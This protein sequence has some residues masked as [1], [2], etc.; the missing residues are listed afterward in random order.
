MDLAPVLQEIVNRSG[1]ASGNA[2][3]LIVTGSGRRVAVSYEGS[4]AGAPLLH[5]EYTTGPPANQAPTVD[6][7]Q[8]QTVYVTSEALLDGAVTDDGLPAP[9]GAVTTAWDQ[10]SGPGTATLTDNTAVDTA[11]SF[12]GPG[13]YVLRLSAD[14]GELTASDEV[15]ISAIAP[16][17]NQPPAVDAG[18]DRTITLPAPA[19]LAGAVSDDGLPDPPG[20]VTL[21]WS[22][23][24]GPGT[25]TFAD[26]GAPDTTAAFA[27]D[28]VY[29]LRLSAIDGELDASDEMTVTVQAAVPTLA[30]TWRRWETTL[31]SDKDYA[32]PYTDASVAVTY[33]GPS[34]QVLSSLGFW[35]GEDRFKIR[36]M[37]PAAGT[38]TWVTTS[39]DSSNEGLHLQGGS[40]TVEPYTGPNRLYQGGYLQAQ[41]DSRHLTDASGAPFLWIGDTAW[42][43]PLN[44]ALADWQLY[45]DD[46]REKQ[47]TVLHL[48]TCGQWGAR[49]DPDTGQTIWADMEGNEPFLGADLG[50]LNPAFWQGYEQ[51]VQYANDRGLVVL[52]VGVMNPITRG[53]TTDDEAGVLRFAQSFAARMRGNFVLFSPGFDDEELGTELADKVAAEIER[54]SDVHLITVH[55]DPDSLEYVMQYY[56]KPYLDFVSL[57]TGRGAEGGT[58]SA[59]LASQRAIQR[60]L[61]LYGE[62]LVRPLINLEAR[63]DGSFTQEQMPRLP[64]SLGYLSMLSGAKG[65]SY[66][67][68]GLWNWKPVGYDTF[69]LS[70]DTERW[71]W[72]EA[73]QRASSTDMRHKSAF[74]AGIEWWRLEPRHDLIQNQALDDAWEHKMAF[75]L[76]P[77]GDLGVAYLP[78]NARIDLDMSAFSTLVLA[79]WYDPSAGVYAAIGGK[80]NNSGVRSLETP[81]EGDWLLVLTPTA[82]DPPLVDAGP[83]KEIALGEEDLLD[84]T[85]TDDGLPH[86]PG[87]TAVMWSQV[88]GPGTVTLG[89]ASA[90]DTTAYF[91][92]VGEYVLRL[93]ADDGALTASD[94][95]TITVIE[96]P[97]NQAPMVDAGPDQDV[98]IG[99]G[100]ALEGTVSDDGWPKP[101][102]VV[103]TTWSQDAGP[104]TAAFADD[105]AVD[106]T[107]S[108]SAGPGSGT[109]VYVLRLTAEDGELASS[110]VVTITVNELPP[111]QAPTVDAGAAITVTLGQDALLDGTVTDD[112]R[113]DPPGAVTTTWSQISGPGTAAFG[114]AA[115]VDTTASFS[116]DQG[117]AAGEYVLRLTAEDGELSSSDEVT[118]TVQQASEPTVIEAR[119]SASDDDAE[120]FPSG[121]V[122][123]TSPDLELIYDGRV[124]TVGMRFTGVDL[125]QGATV[126][127]AYVQFQ[128]SEASSEATA[129]AIE[130]DATD[131]A[132]AFV[133][134]RE[135]IRS[136]TRTIAS[137]EWS[138]PAWEANGAGLDQQTPSL[139]PILQEIV[140]PAGMG[141]RQRAGA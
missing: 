32:D 131:H 10:V 2:L 75:A 129:L 21:S 103:T 99:E 86:P 89:N 95:V 4:P 31:I 7:G 5:V 117:S 46:R 77:E 118:V 79:R 123:R 38:W 98:L 96:P 44:A 22:Q 115:S 119:V 53:I 1:W 66:G 104:G 90:V 109:G 25:V 60:P 76:S 58:A 72:Q 17:V 133:S 94:E 11:V 26:A 8:D 45:V 69:G 59:A 63:Y 9:P 128:A 132:L 88:S 62:S 107:V 15:T 74:W 65:Y 122:H 91:S 110:D 71:T 92:A 3:A 80:F 102:G 16:P 108:F 130:G 85:V 41:P 14:D 141:V 49:Q 51:K 68:D 36:F 120:E 100:A 125:P 57:H 27:T 111:N 19:Q 70:Y 39:S 73:L 61:A 47:F 35:D 93:T 43:A 42:T 6:A 105:G 81:G 67:S 28:G 20:E 37:F 40:V 54:V 87:A 113:P 48:D 126:V 78:D 55:P 30:E 64:R 138:P 139:A 56:D 137:V 24:S 33:T 23:V 97:P 101:P 135:D 13:E 84:G 134:G 82:N 106:T 12:S 136:R 124:Q 18:P 121:Y 140:E 114:D 116:A 83:P 50:R 29:V 34:G 112:G 127:A 52:V